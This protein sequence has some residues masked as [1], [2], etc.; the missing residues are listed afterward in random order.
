MGGGVLPPE[1][2]DFLQPVKTTMNRIQTGNIFFIRRDVKSTCI[3]SIVFYLI[4]LIM[5]LR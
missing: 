1:D 2:P 4:F 5:L 3:K